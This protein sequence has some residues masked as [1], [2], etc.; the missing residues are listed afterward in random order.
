M[1]NAMKIV[2]SNFDNTSI[3][4][5][6][7]T[8]GKDV[9]ELLSS[10][11]YKEPLTIYRE[12]IQNAADAIDE[13]RSAG[14]LGLEHETRIEINL[15][16][17]GRKI[18][19]RDN[20][21][22]INSK[23]FASRMTAFGASKKRGSEARGFRG[24]GRL[25]GLGV[26]QELVFRS[27]AK[28]EILVNELSWNGRI[29]KKLLGDVSFT[30][31]LNDLVTQAVSIH[32]YESDSYPEH[33]FEVELVK[34]LRLRNDALLNEI[35]VRDYISQVAPVPFDSEY[36][37]SHEIYD[38]LRSKTKLGEFNIFINSDE[39]PIYKPF[40]DEVYY[41]EN[42]SGHAED[43][44]CFEIESI[45]GTVAA[46][47]WIQH[48]DY[49]GAIPR[50]SGVRGLRARVG[51]IQVG[52]HDIF[53][54]VF[55]ESRFNSW[56][57]GEV[58][59]LDRRIIPNGR[60][61]AFE[62]NSHLANIIN[63][64]SPIGHEIAKRCRLESAIRNKLKTFEHLKVKVSEKVSVIN[65]GVISQPR[66]EALKKDIENSLSEMHKI[67]QSELLPKEMQNE[68]HVQVIEQKENLP[69][70]FDNSDKKISPFEKL[71]LEQKEVYI[72]VIDL[73]Y[74]CSVNQVVAK[75]LVD[76]ILARIQLE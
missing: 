71:S 58:H 23:D 34:P 45:D 11:M 64:L 49:Q 43:I 55:P 29:I 5:Q 76:N 41:N 47:G 20:G 72:T 9:L 60:R 57:I 31:D 38:W 7:I 59:I 8:I 17:D 25:A 66:M 73:I 3:P 53:C 26:C 28:N 32:Q 12:Y 52:G 69:G 61:D 37:F 33:F 70:L 2:A 54:D 36:Y 16:P 44:H 50:Q 65:Q 42:R 24:V 30:G 6:N 18:R 62:L 19:I 22:G 63:H 48:H 4:N 35:S 51:N 39:T 74:D 15:D 13:A 56:T 75:K 40:R 14:V 68:L 10:S 46:V 1:N 67:S 27:R 21:I